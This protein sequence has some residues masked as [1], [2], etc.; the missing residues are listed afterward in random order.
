MLPNHMYSL[1][2]YLVFIDALSFAS[3][4]DALAYDKNFDQ[5]V[6]VAYYCK[7]VKL[8]FASLYDALAYDTFRI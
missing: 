4:Y 6:T 5:C 3:L 2:S 7:L 1:L 8:S